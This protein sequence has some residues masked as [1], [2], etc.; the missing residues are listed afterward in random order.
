M[1]TPA[2]ATPQWVSATLWFGLGFLLCF[3]LLLGLA[4]WVKSLDERRKQREQSEIDQLQRQMPRSPA[5]LPRE[6]SLPVQFSRYTLY[7]GVNDLVCPECGSGFNTLIHED[8]YY[9]P[10]FYLCVTCRYIYQIGVGPV[11]RRLPRGERRTQEHFE[12]FLSGPAQPAEPSQRGAP[13]VP[14]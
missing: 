3:V 11:P 12:R 13:D 6:Q 8:E 9:V 2:V 5:G 14:E 10:H 4:A 1:T 7:A